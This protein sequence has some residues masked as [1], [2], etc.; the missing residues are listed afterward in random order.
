MQ[1]KIVNRLLQRIS[2]VPRMLAPGTRVMDSVGRV[3]SVENL[4]AEARLAVRRSPATKWIKWL[5]AI[6]SLS[7]SD[8]NVYEIKTPWCI[9]T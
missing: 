2:N 9:K 4:E 1:M 5:E 8:E 3:H 7:I 6:A